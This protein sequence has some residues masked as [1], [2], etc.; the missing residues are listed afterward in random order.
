MPFARSDETQVN[1][2]RSISIMRKV[3]IP[4]RTSC[5]GT[6][7][8]AVNHLC[9]LRSQKVNR[10]PTCEAKGIPTVVPGPKK[11]PNAPA[12]TRNWL[13]LVTGTV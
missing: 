1:G 12:G 3:I 5:Q 2:S 9:V 8:P 7:F 6:Q 10:T 13:T 11:S 4:V